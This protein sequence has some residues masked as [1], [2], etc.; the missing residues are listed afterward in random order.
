MLLRLAGCPDMRHRAREL[1]AAW[2]AR[3]E[4]ATDDRAIYWF[5]RTACIRRD[6]DE[7]VFGRISR[8]NQITRSHREDVRR[9]RR[10][11]P[12]I[13]RARVI[14]DERTAWWLDVRR[15]ALERARRNGTSTLTLGLPRLFYP[16]P[17]LRYHGPDWV[18][19]LLLLWWTGRLPYYDSS[20]NCIRCGD[21]H[22]SRMHIIACH[23]I[24][25]RLWHAGLHV[26]DSTASGA[27][28]HPLDKAL[29][30][31]SSS[32]SSRY[33]L[34][35]HRFRAVMSILREVADVDARVRQ[36]RAAGVH[37]PPPPPQPGHG[38]A[39]S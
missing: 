5:W 34:E 25:R 18:T 17:L 2:I 35:D 13:I 11:P 31:L 10:P 22:R 7:S 23:S 36:L 19:G 3:A 30:R 20:V 16:I 26:G 9:R 4:H 29:Q 39:V 33:S 38:T 37:L 28:V 6:W 24:R 15:Q 12:D 32:S 8:N 1:A 14:R 21:G 27:S